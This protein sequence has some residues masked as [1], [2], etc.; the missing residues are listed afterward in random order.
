M[1]TARALV[2]IVRPADETLYFYQGL[3]ELSKNYNVDILC[4]TTASNSLAGKE[5]T[6]LM[7]SMGIVVIFKNLF[8]NSDLLPLNV[9]EYLKTLIKATDYN[10]V[11]SYSPYKN[12][13][14]RLFQLQCFF[15][16]DRICRYLN[17]PF[18]F[19]S[20][21]RLSGKSGMG[22]IFIFNSLKQICCLYSYVSLMLKSRVKK[23]IVFVE[24]TR[25]FY[26]CLASLFRRNIF[27]EYVF[28]QKLFERHSSL[29]AYASKIQS[30]MNL[31]CYFNSMEY[32]YIRHTKK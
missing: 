17:I 26:L 20:E 23:S 14:F 29:E 27:V 24:T 18:G 25:T 9:D 21:E 16:C 6:T 22:D 32:Y 30:L 1:S 8:E 13:D 31:N 15:T 7:R 4:L 5:L 19:F 2:V 3:K 10:L 28:Q 12:K 11:I